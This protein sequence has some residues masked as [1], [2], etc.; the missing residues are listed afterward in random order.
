MQL[1]QEGA[2]Q[3]KGMGSVSPNKDHPVVRCIDETKLAGLKETI[4][5]NRGILYRSGDF[6]TFIKFQPWL[7]L[8]NHVRYEMLTH[9]IRCVVRQIHV[10]NDSA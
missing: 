2:G 10:L 3:E 5:P 7:V 1:V 8:F 6:F 4:K 9:I